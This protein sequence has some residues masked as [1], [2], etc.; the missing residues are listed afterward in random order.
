ML[1]DLKTRLEGVS[2]KANSVEARLLVRIDDVLQ[3]V[4]SDDTQATGRGVESLR[5]LWL[6]AVP[7]CS[8]LSKGIEKVLICYEESLNS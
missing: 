3:H 2:N 7:W 8:E 5:Q 1:I 6:N 4:R